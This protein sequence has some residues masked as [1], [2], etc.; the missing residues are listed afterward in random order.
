M[1]FHRAIKKRF[2]IFEELKCCQMPFLKK[3]IVQNFRNIEL[4]ELSFSPN[5]NCICGNNGEGK[6]NLLDAVHYLSLTKSVFGLSDKFNFRHG[7]DS[8][9]ISGTYGMESGLETKIAVSVQDGAEKKV[10]RDDKPYSRL[11]DHIGVIPIVMVCPSDSAMVSES[12]EERRRFVNG[13]LSQ[14]DRE[15]LSGLQQY[16]K[17]L[18]SRNKLLKDGV[19]DGAYLSVL[20]QK[21]ESVAGSVFEKRTRFVE[22]LIP[23]VSDLYGTI[24]GGTERISISYRSDLQKGLLFDL[25]Q[26]SIEKDRVLKYTSVGLQRDDFIFELD[27]YPIRKCGSQGQQ[28]SFLVALKFAQYEIMKQ[29]YG[30]PPVLLLDDL[31]DKL[32]MNRVSNLLKMVAGNDFGQIFLTDCNK[33]RLNSIVKGLTGESA[34]FET[35]GGK[36]SDGRRE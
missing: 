15:Y 12:G 16:N 1:L 30:F 9:A 3:I 32:D 23:L 13:V 17:L 2:T 21:M 10:R 14:M 20:D 8:F 7:C 19:S 26:G 34:F 29:A 36:F 28:K 5:I 31:F 24:S 4:Q 33:V 11:S 25:L 18:L 22:R 6:T 35:V 27:G